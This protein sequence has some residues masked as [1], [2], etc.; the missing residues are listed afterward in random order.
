MKGIIE[1]IDVTADDVG[2]HPLA[3]FLCIPE[4]M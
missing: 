1:G 3:L 2:A 4:L